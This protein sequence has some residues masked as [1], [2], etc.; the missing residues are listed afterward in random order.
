M[1]RL[2]TKQQTNYRLQFYYFYSRIYARYMSNVLL[3]SHFIF[4]CYSNLIRSNLTN[5]VNFHL[6]Y[7]NF[8]HWKGVLYYTSG[9]GIF[10]HSKH[11][12]F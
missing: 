6:S 5:F 1:C 8:E 2:F 7:E 3:K 11:Y 9:T 4:V 10:F 12:F